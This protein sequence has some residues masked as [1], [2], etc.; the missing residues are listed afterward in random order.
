MGIYIWKPYLSKLAPPSYQARSGPPWWQHCAVHAPQLPELVC[1]PVS[2]CFV[3][4]RVH[5]RKISSNSSAPPHTTAPPHHNMWSA[6]AVRC[7]HTVNTTAALFPLVLLRF[8]S[9]STQREME[10]IPSDLH[11][12]TQHISH[13][14]QTPVFT[15]MSKMAT[16]EFSIHTSNV[17]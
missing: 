9:C 6:A 1:S 17:S 12:V 14:F 5:S 10:N 15:C 13:C 8:S 7:R 16:I 11:L 4:A 2:E 3:A